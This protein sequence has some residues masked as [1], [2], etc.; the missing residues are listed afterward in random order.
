M[1]N[2]TTDFGCIEEETANVHDNEGVPSQ[3][4]LRSFISVSKMATD[5]L[6]SNSIA[7]L[8]IGTGDEVLYRCSCKLFKPIS[9]LYFCRH[10]T[11]LRCPE[12]V[13]HEVINTLA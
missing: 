9:R 2:Y 12:C 1:G 4:M 13:S 3:R 10:C 6:L 8:I 5:A 11:K 7:R